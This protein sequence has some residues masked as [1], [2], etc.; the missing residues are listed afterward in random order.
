MNKQ[1]NL[2]RINPINLPRQLREGLDEA[3]KLLEKGKAAEALDILQE[4]DKRYPNQVYVLE[5]LAD[6][7]FDLK[8]DRG[9][10]RA[11]RRLHRLTPN[12]PH[13]KLALANAYLANMLPM[14]ALA[15][16]RE[17]LKHWPQH[18]YADKV[19]KTVREIEDVLPKL[20]EDLGLN[21]EANFEFACQHEEV[22]AC[23]HTGEFGRAKAIIEKMQRQKPDFTASLNNL[24]QI[25]WLEGDL[26]RAIETCQ[27]VLAVE[28]D[29]VHALANLAR[30]LY[31]TG[32][33]E[34]AAPLIERLKAST[35]KASERWNKIAEA[36]AFIGDD[37]GI[38]ELARRAE[39]EAHPIELNEHFYHLVAVSECLL[40]KEK[41]ARAHW[42]RA[43]KINANFEPAQENLDDLKKPAH[44]R[45]GPWAFP[46]EQMLPQN[47]IH[48][49]IRVIERAVK[50]KDEKS[51][52]TAVC[53]FLDNHPEL[54]QMAPLLLERG[55][56]TAKEYVI[57]LADMSA[58]PE[59]LAPLKEYAFGQRG[60]D[61]LRMK[62]AQTLS[63]HNAAPTGNV[64]M[65]LQGQ[66]REILLLGFEITSEPLLDESPLNDK[67]LG[68]MEKAIHAL[69]HEDGAAAEKHLRD[70]LTFHPEHPSL[71]NNLALALFMQDKDEEAEAITQ[72]V[73]NDFPDYFFGQMTLA[74]KSIQAGEVD[75]ARSI[76]NHW[77][78]AKKKYH[79]TEFS[80]LCKAQIDLFLAEKNIEGARSW[81]K[82]WESTEPED[83]LDYEEYRT[84]LELANLLS[85]FT[86][87]KTRSQNPK[88]E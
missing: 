38:L 73:I 56:A 14:L 39:T 26:P 33:K 37:Q 60:P 4:L 17:F 71:L 9:H 19:R 63:K 11:V 84:H 35:A 66:W 52:Q 82:M 30:Y 22:Q 74:R 57:N 53:R 40:G 55:D 49:T 25:Y 87:R 5:M 79:I 65:W 12:R 8:D 15:T 85:K 2:T 41:Q 42:Q 68:L 48:E 58:H 76:L 6:A 50:S 27:Q 13:V 72:H 1:R 36:L 80:M 75:K 81:L 7:Y 32:R 18:E 69:R 78:G 21:V 46:I 20:L 16:F 31:L 67:A 29:N 43:L 62:A 44:E 47:I 54:L 83:D 77:M 51:L 24:S 64:K 45:H 88:K 86:K 59:L 3:D 23:L 61:H 70:A 34:E 10:L 28:A